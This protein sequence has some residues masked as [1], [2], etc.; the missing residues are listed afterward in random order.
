MERTRRPVIFALIGLIMCVIA[1]YLIYDYKQPH[2]IT[3]GPKKYTYKIN[4]SAT[5]KAHYTDNEFYGSSGSPGADNTAYIAKLTDY[6]KSRFSYSFTG[7]EATN[8]SYSYRADAVVRS[9]FSGKDSSEE[10]AANVWTQKYSL[11]DTVM[12]TKNTR[13]LN[14]NQDIEIPFAEYAAAAAKFTTINDVPLNSEVVVTYTVKVSGK[15]NGVPFDD[16]QTSTVTAPLDQRVYRIEVKFNKTD[17]KEVVSKQALQFR[18][19]VNTYEFPAAVVLALLGLCLLVYGFRKQTIKSPY[20]REL[21]QIYRYNAGIIVKARRPVSLKHKTI[22]D[23]D[24]FED[25]LSI[26]EE[27]GTSIVAHEP[28]DTVARATHFVVTSG[29]TAYV[30]TLGGTTPK[31]DWDDDDGDSELPNFKSS[32]RKSQPEPATKPTPKI[33]A[34]STVADENK[35]SEQ[36]PSRSI[37]IQ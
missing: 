13:A 3:P 19:I 30:F 1:G 32:S 12:G 27:T 26:A 35:T 4:Q 33:T 24:S 2:P 21:A 34:K 36:R 16:T 17:S 7:S 29:D 28:M 11:L 15:V 8:L 9:K 20:Q 37:K 10:K 6:L 14:F 25:L 31:E 5:S 23:L 18:N 22:V